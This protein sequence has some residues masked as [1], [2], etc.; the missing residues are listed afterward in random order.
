MCTCLDKLRIRLPNLWIN[1]I[2]WRK[3][4]P[5]L[6]LGFMWNVNCS[7]CFLVRN[8]EFANSQW[9]WCCSKM[10]ESRSALESRLFATSRQ[11][12]FFPQLNSI[13]QYQYMY[14]MY[15]CR[16]TRK[17]G[18]RRLYGAEAW[19]HT[20]YNYSSHVSLLPQAQELACIPILVV[21][22][23]PEKCCTRLARATRLGKAGPNELF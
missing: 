13:L 8:F 12:S 21:P 15:I 10:Y 14:I 22:G 17:S 3:K 1:C 16:P 23:V 5:R 6:E 2:S 19:Y 20:R 18:R 9:R 4:G 11:V 7:P